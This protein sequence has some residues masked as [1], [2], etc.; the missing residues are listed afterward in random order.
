MN[1]MVP[2]IFGTCDI[3]D[4]QKAVKSSHRH[5]CALYKISSLK[6]ARVQIDSPP[7]IDSSTEHLPD[8]GIDMPRAGNTLQVQ[9]PIARPESDLDL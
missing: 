5:R 8:V 3:R 2:S 7:A 9:S 4:A 1:A 6:Y